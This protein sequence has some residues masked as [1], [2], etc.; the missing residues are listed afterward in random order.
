M[1]RSLKK[2]PFV[3]DSLLRKVEKQ[4]NAEDKSVIKT[5][6]RAS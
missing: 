6:S 3:A 4:N 1:G 2:G 5:W